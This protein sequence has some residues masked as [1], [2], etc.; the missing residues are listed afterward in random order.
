VFLGRTYSKKVSN[1]TAITDSHDFLQGL[2]RYSL[3]F[4]ALK[5]YILYKSNKV[6][7]DIVITMK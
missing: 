4:L 1:S 7:L 5:I 6:V 2:L 3:I